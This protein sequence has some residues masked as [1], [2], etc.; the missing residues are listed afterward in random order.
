MIFRNVQ[1]LSNR[2]ICFERS[3][4][5]HLLWQLIADHNEW[6]NRIY[7]NSLSNAS[8][9]YRYRWKLLRSNKFITLFYLAIKTEKILQFWAIVIPAQ[10]VRVDWKIFRFTWRNFVVRE[11]I[12]PFRNS[13]RNSVTWFQVFTMSCSL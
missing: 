1:N 4:V 13:A 10:V 9:W 11:F 5:N 12:S 3:S 6:P 7:N 8:V 2:I